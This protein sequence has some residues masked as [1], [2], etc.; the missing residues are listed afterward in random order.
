MSKATG[1]LHRVIGDY[2][3]E[4]EKIKKVALQGQL[5]KSK[6]NRI[7]ALRKMI[8]S[9]SNRLQKGLGW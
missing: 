4:V 7:K 9:T 3:R 5:P 6:V 8:E 2:M 1:N